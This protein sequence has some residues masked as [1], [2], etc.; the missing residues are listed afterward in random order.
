MEREHMRRSNVIIVA[1]LVVASIFFLWLWNFLGFHLLDMRDLIITIIW[2]VITI[3]LCYAIHRAEMH[4]RERIR[5]LFVSD[6]MLYNSE[7]GIIRI[8]PTSPHSY[9]EAMRKALEELDYGNDVRPDESQ[10]HVRFKCTVH[11]I[12]FADDGDIWKGDVIVL[13]DAGSNRRFES[14]RE[15]EAILASIGL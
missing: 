11:S 15:L 13:S 6:G 5:T 3:G 4:R 8:D 7:A 14:A 12:K 10:Q 1:I 9:V 2:W